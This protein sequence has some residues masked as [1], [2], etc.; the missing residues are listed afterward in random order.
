MNKTS[1]LITANDKLVSQII[2][3]RDPLC[4]LRLTGCTHYTNDP[5]HVFGRA[6]MATR[7]ELNAVYGACRNCHSFVDTH[8]D[9]KG[10]HF[11]NIMGQTCYNELKKRSLSNQKFMPSD[12]KE[13]NLKLKE[14][15]ND[16]S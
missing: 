8:P 12:L 3:V 11:K 9:Q 1:K 14:R 10:L 6:N 15:L 5:A 13:I 7:W 4:R 2:K 16:Q